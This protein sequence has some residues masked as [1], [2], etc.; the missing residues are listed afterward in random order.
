MK[1]IIGRCRLCGKEKELTFEHIPPRATFNNHPTKRYSGVD[2][3][4]KNRAPQL[5]FNNIR[6]KNQQQ[7]AGDYTLCASCNNFVGAKYN[8]EYQGFINDIGFIIMSLP[9]ESPYNIGATSSPLDFMAILKQIMSM[10][11]SISNT[12]ST[13]KR[14]TDFILD[15]KSMDFDS[16]KYK[17]YFY[18][19]HKNSKIR[20]ICG[21]TILVIKNGICVKLAEIAFPPVGFILDM[22]GV[23]NNHNIPGCDITEF[24]RFP[25]GVKNQIKF[26]LPVRI[27]ES[28]L[29]T[30]FK[31]L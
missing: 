19:I 14:L 30:S 31:K 29:I 21:D 6:Y 26:S 4:I 12:C 9:N 16:N 18:G 25:Y 23:S 2:I 8:K 10:F 7:G 13:D 3:L 17:L 11:C 1:K 24:S 5:N 22:T 28:E 27:I 15:E 20:R